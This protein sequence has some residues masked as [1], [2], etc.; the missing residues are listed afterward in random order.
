MRF[1]QATIDDK[2]DTSDLKVFAL[3]M[4]FTIVGMILKQKDK[5]LS[6]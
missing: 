4:P 3:T 6:I 1:L 5:I 2:S